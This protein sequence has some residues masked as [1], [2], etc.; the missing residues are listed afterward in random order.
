[1]ALIRA[2]LNPTSRDLAWF[3]LVPLVF[4]GI[5]GAV[6]RFQFES[7]KTSVVLWVVGF[8]ITGIYCSARAL[9]RP[10]YILW[11]RAVSPIGWTIW[12]VSMVVTFFLVLTPI[13]IVLRILGRDPLQREPDPDSTTYWI[14]QKSSNELSGYFEQF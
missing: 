4:F 3:S 13:G 9:R 8:L 1:M 7:P 2:N 12:N 6:L 10:I 11:M 5:L 14:E